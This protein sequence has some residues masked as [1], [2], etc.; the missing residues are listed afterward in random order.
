MKIFRQ[1]DAHY[2][3]NIYMQL[4]VPN[5][6]KN[7]VGL[8]SESSCESRV[9]RDDRGTVDISAV[10]GLRPITAFVD[11]HGRETPPR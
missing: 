8:Y 10:V 11:A 4:K 9:Y 1:R 2:A 7:V 3:T 6:P 5:A